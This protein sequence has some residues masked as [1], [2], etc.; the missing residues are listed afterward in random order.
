[1][2][3]TFGDCIN[4]SAARMLIIPWPFASACIRSS[5]SSAGSPK[6]DSAPCSSEGEEVPLDGADAGRGDVPVLAP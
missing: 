5:R 6:S 2:A 1:M 3:Y 4:L